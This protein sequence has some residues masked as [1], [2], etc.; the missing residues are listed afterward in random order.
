[1]WIKLLMAVNIF[2]Y[3]LTNGVIG[4][5]MAGQSI[6][7]LHTIGRKSG[8]AYT[9]PTAY[10]QD[11][12]DYILVASNWGKAANPNWFKNLMAHPEATVQVQGRHLAVRARQAG[13]EEYT[14]LWAKYRALT[15]LSK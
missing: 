3:R 9:T 6:L 14:R 7:L 13:E 1:M 8:K 11:G 2:L 12:K 4:G 10:I 5:K 15:I